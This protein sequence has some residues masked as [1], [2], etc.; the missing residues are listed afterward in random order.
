[1]L[2]MVGFVR[3]NSHF[4]KTQGN[5]KTS[6]KRFDHGLFCKVGILKLL[7]QETLKTERFIIGLA[8]LEA[9]PDIVAAQTNNARF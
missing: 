9:F 3:Q 8:S 7:D 6:G 1:M 5:V 4:K 2:I